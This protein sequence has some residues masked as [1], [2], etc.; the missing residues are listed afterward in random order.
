[1]RTALTKVHNIEAGLLIEKDN[2]TYTFVYK[3]NYSGEPVSLTMPIF[4]KKYIFNNFP[5]FFEGLLP[6]GIMLEGL[7]KINKLDKND[8]FSQLI[9]V[10]EDVIGA[11]TLKLVINE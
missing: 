9:S 4:Q 10:G 3:D 7:L 5:P 11:V 8:Y 2:N 6:E 1:M